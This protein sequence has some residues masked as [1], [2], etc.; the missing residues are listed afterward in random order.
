MAAPQR[1][2][3]RQFCRV[4]G[5]VALVDDGVLAAASPVA[6]VARGPAAGELQKHQQ[7]QQQQHLE[8]QQ[9]HHLE[10]QQQ[11]LPAWLAHDRVRDVLRFRAWLR[12]DVPH[13]AD[14][15]WRVR[16]CWVN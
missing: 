4:L 9:Q 2:H 13:C 15:P 14:E 1:H 10:Q 11:R 3:R 8:Q 7:Q 6:A 16:R 12:E 5:G